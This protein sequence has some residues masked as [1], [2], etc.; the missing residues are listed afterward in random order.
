MSAARE[1][2][3]GGAG[4]RNFQ[5]RR[6]DAQARLKEERSGEKGWTEKEK[7]EEERDLAC[8]RSK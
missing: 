7:E 6:F 3:K 4:A 1:R 8:F 5:T 2:D